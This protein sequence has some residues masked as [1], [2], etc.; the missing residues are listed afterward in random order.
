MTTSVL[1]DNCLTND[2]SYFKHHLKI[3]KFNV[4]AL[5]TRLREDL[6]LPFLK[7]FSFQSLIFHIIPSCII[8]LMLHQ[9]IISRQGGVGPGFNSSSQYHKYR[10]IFPHLD[11]DILIFRCNNQNLQVVSRSGRQYSDKKHMI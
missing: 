11:N 2:K 8:I 7:F 10:S 4:K 5:H 9:S 3:I 1:F 6:F